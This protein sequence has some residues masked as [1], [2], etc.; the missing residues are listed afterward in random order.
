MARAIVLAGAARIAL[1]VD[2]VEQLVLLDAGQV[3]TARPDLAAE[4]GERSF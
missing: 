2:A 3:E 1:A 4:A